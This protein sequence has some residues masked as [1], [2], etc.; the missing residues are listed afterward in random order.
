MAY[1]N[2][3]PTPLY[4]ETG[5]V[6]TPQ[7][8]SGKRYAFE[9][10]N[11]SGIPVVTLPDD[12]DP[13]KDEDVL[14]FFPKNAN[15]MICFQSVKSVVEKF[16]EK[17][18]RNVYV[19]MNESEK[20]DSGF[21]TPNGTLIPQIIYPWDFGRNE[22]KF[23]ASA[24]D[25]AVA[26]EGKYYLW[27]PLKPKARTETS[28]EWKKAVDTLKNYGVKYDVANTLTA[29]YISILGKNPYM[30][31]ESFN[32][33]F[34][35][36]FNPTGVFALLLDFTS[37]EDD[38]TGKNPCYASFKF[39]TE[40]SSNSFSS[41]NGDY[42]ELKANP[43]GEVSVSINKSNTVAGPLNFSQMGQKILHVNSNDLLNKNV[44]FFYSLM[45]SLIVTGD[46][47]TNPKQT[48]K[49]LICKKNK[50]L[51][52]L[53]ET[54]PALNCFPAEHKKGKADSIKLT[55]K[56]VYVNFGN[57]V[58]ATFNNCIGNFALAALR[59]CPVVSF[60]YFFK[61]SGQQTDT[62]VSENGGTEDY[63]C[64]EVGGKNFGYKGLNKKYRSKKV[65]YDED[66]Q[67]SIFR[68]DFE[69]RADDTELQLNAFE[70]FGIIHVTKYT[71]KLTD[72]LNGDGNF[73]TDFQVNVNNKL[74]VYRG[75][76]TSGTKWEDY[77][78]NIS[79][80]HGLDGTS[81]SLTLDK[82][83]M[84]DISGT[85]TQ[86]IGALT[87]V[88]KNG[89]YDLNEVAPTTS[90]LYYETIPGQIFKGY[91]MEIQNQVS[92]GNSQLTVKLAGIQKKLSD[93]KLVNCPFWDG[94]QVFENGMDGVLNYMKS[95]SGCK[96]K[97][98]PDFSSGAGLVSN[99]IL[100]RSWDWQ[101]PST[102]F[103]LGTPVLD[104]LK[105]IAKKINHQF[106]IQPDGCG[107]FYYMDE[108]GCPTW[109]KN[110]PIVRSYKESDIISMD[111]APYLENRYNTFLTLGLLVKN[112]TES[113]Q[114]VTDGEMPGMKFTQADIGVGDYPWSRIITI[115][116]P[117]LVTIKDLEKFHKTNVRF[118]QSL[119]YT[120][121]I[122]VPG[123]YGFHIF[124][125]IKVGTIVFYITGINHSID[126]QQK[127]WIT[128]LSVAQFKVETAV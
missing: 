12:F 39:Y 11:F 3:A 79:I 38:E 5:A 74:S 28:E 17:N 122:T 6:L 70:L 20:K 61:M 59:F 119:I 10:I 16:S 47:V 14:K 65:Y 18:Y 26:A 50:D 105:E 125:K 33:T 77:I 54:E 113:T 21:I 43:T 99:I 51:D 123:W 95:Y 88:A 27:S 7:V 4:I 94:D 108:Y 87:L 107:Y 83:M 56:N 98:V 104:A 116:E 35:S 82:Y 126:L 1:D 49:S 127:E 68:V 75:E 97:Y 55:S 62:N 90:N 80:S 34:V 120:G 109:V 118:G 110:G 36:N 13:K 58:Q 69:F 29:D 24:N 121:T 78:T 85:P 92:E 89:F 117:G 67:T 48:S 115:S 19:D 128:Q 8:E 76:E 91:A 112:D 46:L 63:Y 9:H 64:L 31:K 93:M 44:I 106:I 66:T 124:D 102:N 101:A 72:V 42:I 86:A 100:P 96:L 15:N 22:L 52:I 111:I 114:L 73:S 2:N 32:R 37:W 84:M 41:T 71:G 81:G 30:D 53:N 45:N 103:V 60:S 23:G 57:R 40:S 25:Y